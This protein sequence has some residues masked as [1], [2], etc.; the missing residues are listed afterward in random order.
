MAQE[1][2][3][4][5]TRIGA[6]PWVRVER[7]APVEFNDVGFWSQK[8]AQDIVR[9][10]DII[11]VAWGYE[12]HPIVIAD[13]DFWAFQTVDPTI[14]FWVPTTSD[15]PFAAEV[16]RKYAVL[17]IP[18]MM[19][20][21]DRDYCVRAYVVWPTADIGEPMYVTVKRHWWSLSG[22]LAYAKRTPVV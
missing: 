11:R 8:S 20:W 6:D 22:K 4:I 7:Y 10:S 12:I 2:P 5:F 19:Y 3:R 18:P 9:W 13:W 15:A 17:E 14:T 1:R 21:A 16:R